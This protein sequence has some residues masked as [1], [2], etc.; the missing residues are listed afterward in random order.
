M[1]R[2]RLVPLPLVL[3]LTKTS[4]ALLVVLALLVWPRMGGASSVT[5]RILVDAAG[6]NDGDSF[7]C[8]VASIG[9]VNG[10]GYDPRSWAR[11]PIRP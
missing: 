4:I 6:E 2:A 7:G 10:D 5:S 1:H 3:R 8:S 11:V 9:D